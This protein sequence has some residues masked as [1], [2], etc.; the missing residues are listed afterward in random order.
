[1]VVL[2]GSICTRGGKPLVSRQFRDI[3]RDR[4]TAL[5]A[6]FPSL[7]SNSSSQH[8]SVEDD[9]VRYVYQPL[10]EFYIVLITNK[11]SNI[12]QDIDTL[13]LFASTVSNLV[14]NVDEREI[15][16]SAFEIIG[17]FDE[18]INLGFKENL[19]LSQ[20]QTFL[21]MDSH[22]EKIQ[23]IIER[24]KELEATEE[25]KRRAKE[26]QRKESAKKNMESAFGQVNAGGS[27]GYDM[28]QQQTPSYQPTYQPAPA[29]EVSQAAP[30]LAPR[31]PARGGLQLGKKA[32]SARQSHAPPAI[33]RGSV[34]NP[35]QSAAEPLLAAQPPVFSHH[36]NIQQ[37]P[38]IATPGS[39]SPSASP[40]PSTGGAGAGK[41]PNNGILITINEKVSAQLSRDG[42]IIS[43]EVKGDLQLRINN[44][45]LSN[46]KI[47]CK[48]GDKKHFKTHP[49]VDRN[50]FTSGSVISV[51][52]K[53]KTFPAN[54]QPLG[55]LRWRSVGKADNSS[56]IPI[57]ITAWVNVDGSGVAHVTLEYELTSEF[58]DSHSATESHVQGV[59]ITV[60][61]VSDDVQLQDG[62]NDQISYD[63]SNEGI[64]FQIGEI[65]IED[66]QGSFEFTIP[67]SEEDDL[68]PL[69]VQFDIVNTGV[70]ESDVSLGGVSII[71]VVANNEDEASLP[72][73]LHS[74]V[75]SE[76]Y[77]VQ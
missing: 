44:S 17:A 14:R 68:F 62:G 4:I 51:K 20:V 27:M 43:S 50:L 41:V 73:D 56:L 5:L 22:E 47:L 64:I 65:S 75:T 18:I 28:Y 16:D 40:A 71:D 31:P 66:P 25:R 59:R 37:P 24:N 53:S 26:I 12:L 2:A 60:P 1:M 35:T 36:T 9:N 48:T 42:S 63:V 38:Q 39:F 19:T 15:F 21:E 29:V 23:E 69:E 11:T 7:I 30:A 70:V 10:E 58:I 52:D 8:T 46:A 6:N 54:D 57:V 3:S 34:S 74:H 33:S 77:I 55:V 32:G 49:N 45:A 76:N 61:I 72:F 13:H 67:V